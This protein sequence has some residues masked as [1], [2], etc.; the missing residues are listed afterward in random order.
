MAAG[1]QSPWPW[2]RSPTSASLQTAGFWLLSAAR[3]F[4]FFFLLFVMYA[5]ISYFTSHFYSG[6]QIFVELDQRP[7]V[8]CGLGVERPRQG[9]RGS[10]S[11]SLPKRLPRGL[12][13]AV[14]G[15]V[16]GILLT[17]ESEDLGLTASP[18]HVSCATWVC[19]GNSSEL[20]FA[21]WSTGNK[22]SRLTAQM[23][24]VK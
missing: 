20:D 23:P 3:F 22:T 21:H 9:L 18:S 14:S 19:H 1:N 16:S 11:I 15:V 6:V 2:G 5:F 7:L 13:L 12:R 8:N 4:F 10:F 17:S 24:K